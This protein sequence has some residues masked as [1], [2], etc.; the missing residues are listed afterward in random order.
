MKG[1]R[2]AE[3]SASRSVSRNAK[4]TFFGPVKDARPKD[5]T[6]VD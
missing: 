3:I 2:L 5:D 6:E 4:F 1:K